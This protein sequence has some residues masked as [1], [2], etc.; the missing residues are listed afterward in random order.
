M[1][2]A[3]KKTTKRTREPKPKAEPEI[4][5]WEID[6]GDWNILLEAERM[7]NVQVQ[8][9]EAQI[10][11]ARQQLRLAIERARNKVGAP[12]DA[13]MKHGR[14]DGTPGKFYRVK[15]DDEDS[16]DQADD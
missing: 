13:Q 10:V 12:L 4:E 8:L 11:N 7:C 16:G 6:Q 2:R 14:A 9:H 5:T 1:A 15:K 3:K